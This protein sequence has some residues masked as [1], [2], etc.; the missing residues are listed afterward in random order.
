[1]EEQISTQPPQPPVI[2]PK[3][4]S[5]MQTLGVVALAMLITAVGTIFAIKIFLF[6][7]T[8]YPG[9]TFPRRRT[10]I[11]YKTLDF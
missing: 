1:M 5:V 10:T 2:Q 6:P 7:P 4:F 3:G 11:I 9:N 8:F